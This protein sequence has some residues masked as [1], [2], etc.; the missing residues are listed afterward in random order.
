VFFTE[1]FATSKNSRTFGAT[2]EE[3]EEKLKKN[4]DAK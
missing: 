2:N 3:V 4:R 1:R